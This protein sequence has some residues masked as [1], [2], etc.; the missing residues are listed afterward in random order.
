MKI[1]FAREMDTSSMLLAWESLPRTVTLSFL[2][3]ELCR[4]LHLSNFPKDLVIL[5]LFF[6]CKQDSTLCC[7]IPTCLVQFSGCSFPEV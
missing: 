6:I 1:C 3:F 7:N 4:A 2:D 5:F